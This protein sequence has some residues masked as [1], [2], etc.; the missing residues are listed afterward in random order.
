MI[1]QPP[2]ILVI[3]LHSLFLINA[4]ILLFLVRNRLRIIIAFVLNHY[5]N[6]YILS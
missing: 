5:I 6:V 4:E 2:I 1:I 3:L